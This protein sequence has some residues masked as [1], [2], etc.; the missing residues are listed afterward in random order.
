MKN[1]AK[2]VIMTET[3]ATTRVIGVSS[4]GTCVPAQSDKSVRVADMVVRIALFVVISYSF[5]R[6]GDYYRLASS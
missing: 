6:N 2:G 4:G 5:V 3:E 1:M